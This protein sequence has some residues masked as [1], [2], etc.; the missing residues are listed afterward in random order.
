MVLKKK[1]IFALCCFF[2]FGLSACTQTELQGSSLA[3]SSSVSSDISITTEA[4][5]SQ[6]DSSSQAAVSSEIEQ[7]EEASLQAETGTESSQT[8]NK[9]GFAS[10]SSSKYEKKNTV[11]SI[12]SNMTLYEK[13]CQMMILSP[14]QLT[15]VSKVTAAGETTK[16]A[17]KKL[18]IGGIL[19][20]AQN[21]VSKQQ[22]RTMLTNTQNY[23]DIPLILTCDEE[24]GR[25]N[26]LMH[27][28]GT[29][30]IGPMYDYKDK[31]TGVAY[32]NAYTI[33][34]DMKSLGFNVDMAP[35]A[36]VWSNPSNTVI[37]N[38]AYSDDFGQAAQLI[39][40]AVK[41]FHAGGVG[42]AL[43]HFPG[44]GDTLADSH[45]GAVYVDKSLAELRENELLPFKAGISAGS[46]MVMIG[47]L[48]LT[49]IDNSQPAPFSSRIVTDL[50]R[51]ELGFQ[52][53]IITDGLQ[54]KAL[55]DSY[56]SGEIAV[57]SVTAGVDMLLCPNDP[58]AAISALQDAVLSGKISE[59]R[60]D[61]SVRRI[62]KMKVNRGILKL[63]Q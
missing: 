17:L 4:G 28:V 46:D 34:S 42:T 24:G 58:S 63:N 52:G 43:K 5:S 9:K 38:R 59:K 21:L 33:A 15:N 19:Y 26:R 54:M 36:D 18:P 1:K 53:V 2:L 56:G 13:I 41:G 47:H 6:E 37:G 44:R 57:R 32:Q 7:K 51:R 40:S 60:I 45:D 23:S 12:I 20:S 27:T 49:K 35:V 48:I 25:V 61:E 62:L 11:D 3:E 50:L 22:V 16:N 30:Y 8:E 39:P 10:E 14:E 55:T 31:G 29:T